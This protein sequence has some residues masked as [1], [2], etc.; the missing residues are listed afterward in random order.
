MTDKDVKP[1]VQQHGETFSGVA[2]FCRSQ[3]L[4]SPELPASAIVDNTDGT[5]HKDA[6]EADLPLSMPMWLGTP[7][8][9][10]G[11]SQCEVLW[12]PVRDHDPP[13]E[14]EYRVVYETSVGP[15]Q[16]YPL[17]LSV[18]Q[19][20]LGGQGKHYLLIRVAH[21]NG[22]GPDFSSPM[23]VIC[24]SR[25]PYRQDD[26]LPLQMPDGPVTDAWLAAN[27]D[28][29][30][31]G[32]PQYAD[33]Q[34]G[35]KVVYYWGQT[36]PLDRIASVAVDDSQW[37]MPLEISG[38]LIRATGSGVC[39]A[40]YELF[41][42]ATNRSRPSTPVSV[43]VV[44]S[45]LPSGLQE[46]VVP[47]AADGLLNLKDAIDGVVVQIPEFDDHLPG[48][49]VILTWGAAELAPRLV[50]D[51]PVF[52]LPVP[53][54]PV[55]L[56]D[57]Y[58]GGSGAV[59]TPVSYRVRRGSLSSEVKSITV[60]VDFSVIGPAPDP[61]TN[62][63][64]PVNS[65]LSAA[66]IYGKHSATLNVLA[67]NDHGEPAS[68][69]FRL[70]EPL[71]PGEIVSFYWHGTEVAEARYTVQDTD[72]PTAAVTVEIPWR[73]IEQASNHVQLPVHYRIAGPG[74]DNQQH[75][76]DTPVNASP[77]PAPPAPAFQGLY[78]DQLLNCDSLYEDPAQPHPLEPAIRVEI[79]DLSQAPYSLKEGDTLTLHWIALA[80]IAGET[81]LDVTDLHEPVTLD[82]AHPPTGFVWRVQ[83]YDTHVLPT[84]DPDNPGNRVGRGRAT[85]A[86]EQ[87]GKP[88]V[89]LQ[90]QALVAMSA[91]N[92]SCPISRVSHI[93]R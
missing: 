4:P 83:P 13:L 80:G 61:G 93:R 32:L 78:G 57:T 92:G 36:F 22:T 17:A 82:A 41:D 26:P 46:P 16:T 47:S 84:Y 67:V 44:L 86:F 6:L 89:S 18:P 68:L 28:K 77:I 56:R 74:S 71:K 65:A 3:T 45:A 23:P 66:E 69:T 12:S 40:Q 81:F 59:S 54:P 55:V 75:S 70:Y 43:E 34:P 10:E 25:P 2:A 30:V 60:D 1:D 87:A 39:Y 8:P 27:D 20:S 62:W 51:S 63:P 5:L 29:L 50:G 33:F 91:S 79:P 88:V 58:S 72:A 9:G 49:S 38:D 42:K 52:P 64:D 21:W 19:S 73:Y 85:Y 24:D 7:G 48:D 14:S 76:P 37:P 90:A 15:D 53:I 31:V 11:Q 35:D